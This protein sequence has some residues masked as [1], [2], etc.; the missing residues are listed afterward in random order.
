[1]TDQCQSMCARVLKLIGGSQG[2]FLF[3]HNA[4]LRPRQ[5]AQRRPT[6][7]LRQPQVIC[8]IATPSHVPRTMRNIW[9]SLGT[10]IGHKHGQAQSRRNTAA[11]RHPTHPKSTGPAPPRH[12]TA[13]LPWTP[14]MASQG[15]RNTARHTDKQH[16]RTPSG[17]HQQALDKVACG[18]AAKHGAKGAS[19]RHHA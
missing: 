18:D 9:F 15:L 19:A 10:R 2:H 7:R 14:C 6:P 5:R 16:S 12:G 1:M 4:R 8:T 17:E 11:P 13:W 3:G